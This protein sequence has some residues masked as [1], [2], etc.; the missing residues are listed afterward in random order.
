MSVFSSAVSHVFGA[1]KGGWLTRG[2]DGPPESGRGGGRALAC[3]HDG[4]RRAHGRDD[5]GGTRR[6]RRAGE[7]G[8]RQGGEAAHAVEVGTTVTGRAATYRMR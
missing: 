2:P 7:H 5:D 6:A 8:G 3:R 4:R 1:F